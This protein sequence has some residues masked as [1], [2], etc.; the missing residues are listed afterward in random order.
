MRLLYA[1]TLG[2]GFRTSYPM[3]SQDSSSLNMTSF[4]SFATPIVGALVW[5]RTSSRDIKFFQEN[6]VIQSE[7]NTAK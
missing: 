6:V 5:V 4:V 1:E 3:K 7:D 2:V